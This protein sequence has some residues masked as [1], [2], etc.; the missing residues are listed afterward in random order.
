MFVPTQTSTIDVWT[1]ENENKSCRI[2]VFL[3]F[4]WEIFGARVCGIWRWSNNNWRQIELWKYF[5]VRW[6]NWLFI[7]LNS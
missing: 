4:L 7:V 5:H 6:D 2:S 3:F 1:L